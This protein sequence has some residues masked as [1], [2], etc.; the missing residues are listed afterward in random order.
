M[1]VDPIESQEIL[2]R[3]R[4]K[5][6]AQPQERNHSTQT[7]AVGVCHLRCNHAPAHVSLRIAVEDYD[8]QVPTHALQRFPDGGQYM[9]GNNC[10]KDCVQGNSKEEL[11]KE[12]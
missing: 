10:K 12:S 6:R 2:V 7:A 5:E 8:T 3:R 9:K 1:A 4:V 11:K